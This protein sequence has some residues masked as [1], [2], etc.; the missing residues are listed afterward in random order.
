MKRSLG[1][2]T[3]LYPTPVMVVAVYDQDG[4]PNA[5]TAAW[6]GIC[7]SSPPCLAVSLRQ[8]T[9]TH[10]QITRRKAF[11]VNLPRADQAEIADFLGLASGRNMDKFSSAGITDVRSELV[12][13]PLVAEFPVSIECRLAHVFELGL[14]TQFVGEIMDVKIDPQALDSQGKMLIEALEPLLFIPDTR[15]YHTVGRRLGQAF[16]MGRKFMPEP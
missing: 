13:A 12:D 8:A 6:G 1:P 14:H 4:R 3:V 9:Y 2:K 10:G 16:S 11:T 5:M 7:C 15:A